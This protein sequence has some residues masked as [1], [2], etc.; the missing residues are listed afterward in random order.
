MQKIDQILKLAE[1]LAAPLGFMVVDVR[2][3]QE[4][5]RRSL[6]VTICRKGDAYH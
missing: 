3:S 4:G 1:D 2:L 6:E 5:K